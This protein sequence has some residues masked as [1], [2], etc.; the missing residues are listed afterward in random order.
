MYLNLKLHFRFIQYQE[1]RVVIKIFSKDEEW[2]KLQEEI[3]LNTEQ[4]KQ[5]INHALE[6]CN[7]KLE[8]IKLGCIIFVLRLL[9]KEDSQNVLKENGPVMN[10]FR[11]I[12]ETGYWNVT[13]K[14]IKKKA[15]LPV[16]LVEVGPFY[17]DLPEG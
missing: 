7:I 9:K 5:K 15:V 12:T 11:A 6:K 14:E 1:G 17:P 4:A 3:I 13:L 16:F 10:L 2:S 8:H